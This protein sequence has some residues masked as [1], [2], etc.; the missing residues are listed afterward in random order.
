MDAVNGGTLKG[1]EKRR[2][3]ELKKQLGEFDHLKPAELPAAMAV[4]DASAEAPP[5]YRLSLGDYHKPLEQVHPGFPA[6]LG[7]SEPRIVTPPSGPESSGRRTALARWLCRPDHPLTARV[8]VNRLWQHHYGRGIV[9]TANDFGAMGEPPT[10]ADLLDWLAVEFVERGW[11]IKAMHRLMVTSAAYRQSSLVDPD[12]PGQALAM[13]ID[14]ANH[15]LWHARRQRLE[16]E[17]I[18]DAMLQLAGDLQPRMFGPSARPRL[19]DGLEGKSAWQMDDQPQERNRRSIYV[20]AKRNLRY[21]LFEIF[22]QPDLH[23]SCPQRSTTTTAPQALALLN[24]EFSLD[25]A[26]RWSGRLLQ[27]HGDDTESLVR[28]AW[29]EA[30]SHEPAGEQLQAALAFLE[31]QT[32]ALAAGGDATADDSLPIPLP[33]DQDPAHSTALVDFCHAIFNSNEFLYVD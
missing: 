20:F 10:H 22:D 14:R 3:Q 21:P 27:R 26:R 15:L 19:P 32:A 25:E 24:G 4:S 16:G 1:D 23:N 30:F 17:A 7:A 13:E 31:R 28:A 8:M 6:F 18:R 33:A 9:A 2:Y 29:I 5:T 12:D 11:S